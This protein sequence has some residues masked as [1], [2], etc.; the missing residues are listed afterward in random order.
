VPMKRAHQAL[1][2]RSLTHVQTKAASHLVQFALPRLPQETGSH[3]SGGQRAVTSASATAAKLDGGLG[4]GW[5]SAKPRDLH[6]KPLAPSIFV[7][8]HCRH[9]L[10]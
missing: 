2:Q 7:I 5:G 9:L 3:P 4:I 10:P 6:R 8:G 1:E